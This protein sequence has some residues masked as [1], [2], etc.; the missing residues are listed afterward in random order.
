[1]SGTPGVP[2]PAPRFAVHVDPNR[3]TSGQ[4]F[5][6]G[7]A[8]ALA[9]ETVG[10]ADAPSAVLFNVSA[11]ASAILAAKLRGRRIV[12]RVDGLYFDRLSP[13]FLARFRS[14]LRTLFRIGLRSRLLRRP[15]TFLAN[16]IDENYA[17]FA[18]ILVADHV[19]YQSDFS[20]RI[21]SG[22]FPRKPYDVITNGGVYV[23]ASSGVRHRGGDE[24][25]LVTIY[26]DWKPA[27][28]ISDLL[29]F[30]AWANEAGGARVRLTVLG[31]SGRIPACAPARM[32]GQLESSPYVRTLPRFTAFHGEFADALRD[33]DVY[34]T[35]TYRDPC[36]NAVIEA[37]AHGLPVV[38]VRSGGMADIVGDAGVLLAAD[39]FSDGFYASHRFD[40]TFPAIDFTAVL[41]GIQHVMK[42]RDDF[43]RRVEQRF[44]DDLGMTVVAARYGDVLRRVAQ[45]ARRQ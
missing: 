17:S 10:E 6:A 3:T 36:P 8:A 2:Q 15:L 23:G 40:C 37:M 29:D 7:L 30:V 26:D 14:P 25:R 44:R 19:V 21:H 18:R 31:Y 13:A 41:R 35:L 34:V 20:R 9:Q 32:R 1:M 33:G 45:G 24:I 5:F 39:D 28:R 38:G 12:L 43:A 11:P 16:L 42:H 27:K 4:R 22:Y